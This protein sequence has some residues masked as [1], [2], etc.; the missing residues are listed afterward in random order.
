MYINYKT[1]TVEH[2]YKG[3]GYK[4]IF[5]ITNKLSKPHSFNT[6]IPFQLFIRS[7]LYREQILLGRR[8]FL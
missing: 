8:G 7:I 4:G 1:Y 5:D 2:G 6:F 3:L